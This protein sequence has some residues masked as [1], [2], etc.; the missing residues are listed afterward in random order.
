MT[1]KPVRAAAI[2]AAVGAVLAVAVAA[3]SGDALAQSASPYDTTF[4][5]RTGGAALLYADMATT[6]KVVGELPEG[7]TGIVLRWCRKEFSFGNWQ[8]GSE[9]D[10]LKILDERWCEV[11]HKGKVGNVPGSVLAP[12]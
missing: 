4:R 7:A 10:K 12:E 8:F 1:G 6:A 2:A 11:S 3:G 5:L 9:R